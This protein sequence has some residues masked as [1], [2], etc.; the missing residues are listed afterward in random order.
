M[1]ENKYRFKLF[2]IGLIYLIY[3]CI[4]LY[5]YKGLLNES[6]FGT[7]YHEAQYIINYTFNIIMFIVFYYGFDKYKLNKKKPYLELLVIV[8]VTPFFSFFILIS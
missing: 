8:K 1:K 5:L 7:V 6:S 3:G 2:L 4:H